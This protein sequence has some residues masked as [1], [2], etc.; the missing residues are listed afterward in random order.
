MFAVEVIFGLVMCLLLIVL[1][2]D[3]EIPE[4]LRFQLHILSFLSADRMNDYG[5][6]LSLDFCLINKE[7]LCFDL[8]KVIF[9]ILI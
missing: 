8:L 1:V 4:L 5:V 9:S 2:T 7:G 3:F 6:C